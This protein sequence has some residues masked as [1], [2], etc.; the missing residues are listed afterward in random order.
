MAT[1]DQIEK[2]GTPAEIINI[3]GTA[4]ADDAFSDTGDNAAW[5][6]T[7]DAMYAS[8]ILDAVLSA[9]PTAGSTIDVYAQL[10][11]ISDGSD[12][13]NVPDTAFPHVHVGSFP[14]DSGQA[15]QVQSIEIAL[16]NTKTQQLYE[17]Y[18]RNNSTGQTISTGSTID[19]VPKVI[20]PEPAA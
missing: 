1:Y 18:L 3:A 13:A 8:L 4:T 14:M 2:F 19:V 7:G 6:N 9:A 17:F 15:A 10:F 20:G 11:N 16:P 12:D 5:I